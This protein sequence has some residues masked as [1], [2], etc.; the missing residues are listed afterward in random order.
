MTRS[1]ISNGEDSSMHSGNTTAERTK[2][3]STTTAAPERPSLQT[4]NHLELLSL[5]ETLN[6]TL[7]T[8]ARCLTHRSPPL[9]FA[10]V[11]NTEWTSTATTS[12]SKKDMHHPPGGSMESA[13]SLSGYGSTT[14]NST[15]KRRG[16]H[17]AVAAVQQAPLS[18][19]L[20]GAS[21]ILSTQR[22]YKG[23][24]G[25]RPVVRYASFEALAEAHRSKDPFMAKREQLAGM[26]AKPQPKNELDGLNDAVLLRVFA[27]LGHS[28]RDAV[29]FSSTCRRLRILSLS[30]CCVSEV[31]LVPDMLSLEEF[32]VSSK[33]A[34]DRLRRLTS[35]AHYYDMHKRGQ[36][37]RSLSLLESKFAATLP[38]STSFPS[39]AIMKS[40]AIFSELPNLAM[41]DVRSV[42]WSTA[43]Q[44]T[45]P[46]F[47]SDL[48]LV[49]P[50]LRTLK[51]GVELYNSWT[52]G[53][54]MRHPELSSLV[55][56][57]RR[58]QPPPKLDVPHPTVPLHADLLA[59]LQ[60]ERNWK[61]KFWSPMEE[62]SLR[63]LICPAT[64]F[65]SLCELTL[66]MLGCPSL[67]K[68]KAPKRPLEDG[69]AIA[70]PR[71]TSLT[72]ANLD[73]NP[74]L[75]VE[76]YGK[77]LAQAP[78]LSFFSV[79]NTVNS[80]PPPSP[81]EWR[82]RV[83]L[84]FVMCITQ[85]IESQRNSDLSLPLSPP[86]MGG[87]KKRYIKTTNKNNK[88]VLLTAET[89]ESYT[90]FVMQWLTEPDRECV[91]ATTP[92]LFSLSLSL[93]HFLR[94]LWSFFSPFLVVFYVCIWSIFQVLLVPGSGT[95]SGVY[96]DLCKSYGIQ[97]FNSQGDP[98][99]L[100]KEEEE[101]EEEEDENGGS[102]LLFG[103]HP[104]KS[105]R[106][107]PVTHYS[108][109]QRSDVRRAVGCA[110][111]VGTAGPA[112]TTL[113]LPCQHVLHIRCVE[114]LQRL[115]QGQLA[116]RYRGRC[117]PS[118]GLSSFRCPGCRGRVSRAVPLFL[119][120]EREPTAEETAAMDLIFAAQQ[121][122]LERL[123]SLE[124]AKRQMEQLTRSCAE[125]HNH[126]A[127]LHQELDKCVG[128]LPQLTPMTTAAGGPAD[129]TTRPCASSAAM[130][131]E[132]LRPEELRA[133]LARASPELVAAQHELR[134][135]RR[136]KAHKT[137]RLERLKAVA[138]KM[139]KKRAALAARRHQFAG[140]PCAP[141]A[142]QLAGAAA[143]IS[144]G[145][146]S[147]GPAAVPL[148]EE[149]W[150]PF[151]SS[152]AISVPGLP[153]PSSQGAE[154][155]AEAEA[156]PPRPKL[157]IDVD[158]LDAT[159]RAADVIVVEE[160]EE[161]DS[162]VCIV[163]S[164]N[165]EEEELEELDAAAVSRLRT[166]LD[167]LPVSHHRKGA[168][169]A[170]RPRDLSLLP[171]REDYLRSPP[172]FSVLST[173]L[174]IIS[175][176]SLRLFCGGHT[177]S[178]VERASL[179]QL[180]TALCLGLPFLSILLDAP[181]LSSLSLSRIFCR[182][183][184]PLAALPLTL[185]HISS[186]LCRFSL[187]SCSLPPLERSDGSEG[188]R[189][190]P[191]EN[192]AAAAAR[193]LAA[194]GR[195]T[196]D[197]VAV[198]AK[199]PPITAGLV[200]QKALASVLLQC[201]TRRLEWADAYDTLLRQEA[202]QRAVVMGF[203]YEERYRW[204]WACHAD[205]EKRRREEASAVR[206]AAAWQQRKYLESVRAFQRWGAIWTEEMNSREELVATEAQDWECL[207]GWWEVDALQ[208]EHRRLQKA[209]AEAEE[210]WEATE[211]VRRFE[212]AV[213]LSAMRP[214]NAY[215]PAEPLE[216]VSSTIITGQ[217]NDRAVASKLTKVA[218]LLDYT[219]NQEE[220]NARQALRLEEEIERT[221]LEAYRS[222]SVDL[223][224]QEWASRLRHYETFYAGWNEHRL[225]QIITIQRWW[226]QLLAHPWTYYRQFRLRHAMR[227][228]RL[229]MT[230]ADI[231]FEVQRL[232]TKMAREPR[233][234]DPA[235]ERNRL[236]TAASRRY[237]P[238]MDEYVLSLEALFERF[239]EGRRHWMRAEADRCLRRK[240]EFDRVTVVAGETDT[241]WARRRGIEKYLDD[242]VDHDTLPP[243]LFTRFRMPYARW[244][245]QRWVEF[246]ANTLRQANTLRRAEEKERA[247]IVEEVDRSALSIRA[248]HSALVAGEAAVTAFVDRIACHCQ[249]ETESRHVLEQGEQDERLALKLQQI[250]LA[251][252]VER[253]QRPM[254][255]L[256]AGAKRAM[257]ELEVEEGAARSELMEQTWRWDRLAAARARLAARYHSRCA[258][259]VA[260]HGL[261]GVKFVSLKS[262]AQILERFYFSRRHRFPARLRQAG[263]SHEE[264]AL[265][266]ATADIL[267]QLRAA[268]LAQGLEQ[269]FK[270][271]RRGL[272]REQKERRKEIDANR[273][274]NGSRGFFFCDRATL[275][276]YSFVVRE[277]VEIPPEEPSA[278]P[279]SDAPPAAE[280]TGEVSAP[281]AAIEMGD[282]M[283]WF[284]LWLDE[285]GDLPREEDYQAVLLRF[286]KSNQ[287]FYNDLAFL[288]SLLRDERAKIEEEEREARRYMSCRDAY[289][290]CVGF[291]VARQEHQARRRLVA[292]EADAHY[293]LFSDVRQ[294]R[295]ALA[296]GNGALTIA[297]QHPS[298]K[299]PWNLHLQRAPVRHVHPDIDPA[300]A[301]AQRQYLEIPYQARPC[302]PEDMYSYVHNGP[303]LPNILA[304]R[305]FPNCAAIAAVDQLTADAIA[306]AKAKRTAVP[307]PAMTPV[308]RFVA[309]EEVV[310]AR[311][312]VQRKREL[313]SFLGDYSLAFRAAVEREAFHTCL[314]LC[315]RVDTKYPTHPPVALARFIAVEEAGARKAIEREALT[316]M[317]IPMLMAHR[318]YLKDVVLMQFTFGH[319]TMASHG[320]YMD[321]RLPKLLVERV[322]HVEEKTLDLV[323]LEEAARS[324]LEYQAEITGLLRFQWRKLK[325]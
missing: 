142:P 115:A 254:M 306:A 3:P 91:E 165:E 244:R 64:A 81:M 292:E 312:E 317:Q 50:Q 113:L 171:R 118:A 162:G 205:K 7:K 15:S 261:A 260:L 78:R 76:L 185:Q 16:P 102:R 264:M 307:L 1:F 240:P 96:Y 169:P 189:G 4:N 302:H 236:L 183:N 154:A 61:L 95:D 225:H 23:K 214:Q 114:Y 163:P 148:A 223:P 320:A 144:P 86:P 304:G 321:R 37:V 291:Q 249:S 103:G 41:L 9:S 220:F 186:V 109:Q 221:A 68:G 80:P 141:Q 28:S 182:F 18:D 36:H 147:A 47:L 178:Y 88:N 111:A 73:E 133:Y 184:V 277:T 138:T 164:G 243:R 310:R 39:C 193:A 145:S 27:F 272:R 56:A 71:L 11:Y 129:S 319:L 87:E 101:E 8:Q 245:S 63:Q 201:R 35:I 167:L 278:A 314:R 181:L 263:M 274:H 295:N 84:H 143:G 30:K 231:K 125:L 44:P 248:F 294:M 83:V 128:H 300:V 239:V 246:A 177:A 52:P 293:H 13:L 166:P 146:C 313:A 233:L 92:F 132:Q 191:S 160:A 59:M 90:A 20:L 180:G 287:E 324:R 296:W 136:E 122:H 286:Q 209:S 288:L 212:V 176:R 303:S 262:A 10:S 290:Q 218:Y 40:L 285:N 299:R 190:A 257:R 25:A 110:V 259:D 206:T 325:I 34:E 174:S 139:K 70:F 120:E 227:S 98:L 197:G 77:F 226:R 152:P 318:Q 55:V 256:I 265:R 230:A 24:H 237:Q 250:R 119:G 69:E 289:Q 14:G 228:R 21:P 32:T 207:R 305:L 172:I 137:R 89:N 215:Q 2:D 19:P 62:G 60:S 198:S 43:S 123:Q 222:A 94:T 156:C 267:M 57:S 204:R 26:Q 116:A 85:R 38:V 196:P 253:M 107:A 283:E 192:Q 271:R 311:L 210:R 200:Q 67:L 242:L 97:L 255:L 124:V 127:L 308:D 235:K 134:R 179:S 140:A 159:S 187:M 268:K 269:L 17:R 241:E 106:L 280:P 53:W 247:E 66:N 12:S 72:I 105:S 42:R 48:Y 45:I 298:A 157:L 309:R 151:P 135:L 168:E 229:Q 238:M 211:S 79:C 33:P 224:L 54:W 195:G 112:R 203:E 150:S 270:A 100:R 93:S 208:V 275:A 188:E 58:D 282:W 251:D 5:F 108:P 266:S 161:S 121:R 22:P 315:G 217:P 173:A 258:W 276:G 126:Q 49:A 219:V 149:C 273:R 281:P 216:F 74:M 104:E 155:E 75:A 202:Q 153:C 301:A 65:H 175:V 131:L 284:N 170:L 323:R 279:P 29:S 234:P 117:L 130:R 82:P 194:R 213:G 6:A 316:S 199:L 99:L 232:E 158:G 252:W 46:F 322:Q 297:V 51:M 31:N